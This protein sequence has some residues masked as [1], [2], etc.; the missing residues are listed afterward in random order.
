MSI[1]HYN[2]NWILKYIA[3]GHADYT[4]LQGEGQCECLIQCEGGQIHVLYLTNQDIYL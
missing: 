2:E 3:E 4:I 1:A